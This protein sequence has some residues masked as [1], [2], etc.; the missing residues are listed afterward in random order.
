MS[1]IILHGKY[2][3]GK[4][5]LISDEDFKKVSHYKWYLQKRGRPVTFL[6]GRTIPLHKLIINPPANLEV[7]HINRNQL[8]NTRENLR[9]CTRGENMRN[10]GG[11]GKSEYKGVY[12]EVQ[13]N[14]IKPWSSQIRINGKKIK[15]GYFKTSEEAARAY[16]IAA[17]KYH[18]AFASINFPMLDL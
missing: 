9:V 4:Y 2:G 7:D 6:S 10:R 15:L 13:R 11:W 18:G 12:K 14:L 17:I 3:R 16:D 1:K 8:D 5:A